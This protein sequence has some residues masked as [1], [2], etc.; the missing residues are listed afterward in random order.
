MQKKTV[1]GFTLIEL[2]VVIAVAGLLVAIGVP[3]FSNLMKDSEI[4]SESNAL[5]G[6]LS[7]TRTESIRRGDTV[8]FGLRDSSN[9][10]GGFVAWI[11]ADNGN[12]W[13]AGEETLR[14]WE[15]FDSSLSIAIA[16]N[17]LTFNSAGMVNVKATFTI[18]DGR[19]AETGRELVLLVSGISTLSE[20]TC[21]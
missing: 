9:I 10:N 13:D 20:K 12:D 15:S 3:S 7:Y 6:A 19:T 16:T 18:C 2:I 8:H 1:R 11:D 4:R 5:M 14:L 21:T 17:Y